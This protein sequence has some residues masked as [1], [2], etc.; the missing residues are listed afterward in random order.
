VEKGLLG[1]FAID[2]CV[3]SSIRARRRRDDLLSMPDRDLTARDVPVP[4]F[5]PEPS[6]ERF[7][8]VLLER[9]D[10]VC[11]FSPAGG[12]KILASAAPVQPVLRCSC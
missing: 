6:E 12:P 2:L 8:R 10:G 7:G 4:D 9:L 1:I 3:C 5:A 11:G